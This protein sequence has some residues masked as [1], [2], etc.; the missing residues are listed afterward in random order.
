M[1][2][3]FFLSSLFLVLCL[4]FTAVADGQAKKPK[5]KSSFKRTAKS[6]ATKRAEL[7]RRRAEEARRQAAIAYQRN[8]QNT[9]TTN[10]LKDDVDGEDMNIRRA[11]IDAL[12]NNPG[13]VV[14]MEAQTGKV[15][16]LVNHDWAISKSFQPCSTIKLVTSVAG[17]NKEVIDE[18][19]EESQEN[20][21]DALAR[22]DNGYFQRVGSN[23]GYEKLILTAKELGLGQPTGIN[24]V[25]EV[26]GKLP[27]GNI[28]RRVYSHGYGFL[29]TPLQL[30]RLVAVIT[31]GGKKVV[32]YV[33]T[34]DGK[35]PV[36]DDKLEKVN[37]P[38]EDLQGVIPG[39]QGAAQY[40]TAR[41]GVDSTLGIAGKTGT[42][43]QTGLFA[44]VAPI[45]NPKYAVVVVTRGNTGKGRYAAAVAGKIYQSLLGAQTSSVASVAQGK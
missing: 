45:N 1:K 41:N 13:T 43:S 24:A 15:L 17:L 39:M 40:G 20:L 33:P 31:N 22:S 28:D 9:T 11:A 3:V 19:D 7:A 37:L 10:I 2:R 38:L 27:S 12:G 26:S 29:V 34:K 6:A 32:P 36:S 14:V 18:T 30:A 16:T 42:C 4:P 44:S 21:E 25:G 5:K 8:L 23:I 35:V